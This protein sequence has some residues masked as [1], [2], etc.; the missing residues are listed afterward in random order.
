MGFFGTGAVLITDINFLIQIIS[1]IFV[2]IGIIFKLKR[3]L[4]IHGYLMSIAVL[5]HLVTFIVVMGPAF[6]DGL[7]FFTNFTDLLGVQAM[8][9]H[10]ITGGIALIVGIFLVSV[11]IINSSNIAGCVKRK[12]IMD[13]TTIL[14]IISFIFGMITYLSFYT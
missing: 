12:R 8:W 7:D 10:A 4:K 2:I 9:I 11:W 1:V 6:S 5:L 13:I 14:W 3:K